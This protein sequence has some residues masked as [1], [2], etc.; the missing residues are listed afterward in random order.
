M[1]ILTYASCIHRF[2]INENG[3]VQID[4]FGYDHNTERFVNI[5]DKP[6]IP[7]MTMKSNQCHI[8][9][10]YLSDK[11]LYVLLHL[12]GLNSSILMFIQI[13]SR[14]WLCHII[15]TLSIP[16][17]TYGSMRFLSI[18]SLISIFINEDKQT[19][20]F[21]IIDNN[22]QKYSKNIQF[23]SCSLLTYIY[24][25]LKENYY[26]LMGNEIDL[27]IQRKIIK[28]NEQL[29]KFKTKRNFL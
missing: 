5:I 23:I 11:G 29:Q 18:N 13:Q 9:G 2:D 26:W 19:N 28:V 3:Y 15:Y 21:Y 7:S 17:L 6:L 14:P 12:I 27:N 24:C 10:S 16:K 25:Y 8:V 22:Q 4:I 20:G 1:N